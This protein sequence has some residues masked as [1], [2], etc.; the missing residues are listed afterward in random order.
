M[1][2][3][4][5]IFNEPVKRSAAP[6]SGSEIRSFAAWMGLVIIAFGVT[7]AGYLFWKIG[8]VLLDPRAFE[9]QVDRWEFVVRGRTS[10]AL[11]DIY[12]I[13]DRR[14]VGNPDQP[15][16]DPANPANQQDHVEQVAQLTGRIASKSARPAAL[17]LI[18]LV[19]G[20][21]VRIAVAIINAGIRLAYLTAGEKDYLKR[22]VDELVAQRNNPQ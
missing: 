13:P 12:E 20:L 22:I 1:K 11:P 5:P 14:P 4:T 15:V 10:D 6:D 21:M 8:N 16:T 19:L 9:T 2:R 3:D 17:I 7:T 18:L